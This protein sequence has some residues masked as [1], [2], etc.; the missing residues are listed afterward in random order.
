MADSQPWLKTLRRFGSRLSLHASRRSSFTSSDSENGATWLARYANRRS[1]A[2]PENDGYATAVEL[3]RV[4]TRDSE[5]DRC[6]E[7]P[8]R[9]VVVE[10]E[11]ES[12]A[13]RKSDGDDGLPVCHDQ[14]PVS[15]APDPESIRRR[16]LPPLPPAERTDHGR[17]QALSAQLAHLSHQ[18]WYWGPLTLEETQTVLADLPDGSFIVRDSHNESYLLAIGLRVDGRTV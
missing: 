1:A 17:L 6:L 2:D 13:R 4:T 7:N 18:G 10:A 14:H 8:P 9:D 15:S 5:Q 16:P 12:T 11:S 3:V